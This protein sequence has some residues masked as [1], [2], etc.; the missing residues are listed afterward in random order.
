MHCPGI[1]ILWGACDALFTPRALGPFVDVARVTGGE[2]EE[3][4]ERGGQPHEVLSAF[5]RVVAERPP[6]VVVLEDLH[7]ADEATLDV[8]RLLGRRVDGVR[9]LILATYRDD[10]LDPAH[11]LRVVLGELATGR[12]VERLALT[13]LSL[14]AVAELA[15]PFGVDAE[16]LYRSTGGNPFFV[17]E[18]LAA[19]TRE[20]P[21]TVGDA[22]LARA[23]RLSGGA[24][25]M[26]EALTV[27]FPEAELWVLEAIAG[28]AM[29]HLDNCLGSGMLV[30]AGRGLAFRRE[31]ARLVIEQSLAPH[32][33]AELHGRAL[34]ALSDSPMAG[35]DPARLAH[36]AEAAG[37]AGAVLRF[38][39]EAAERASV[40]GAHRESAAQYAR[41]LRF[42]DALAPERRAA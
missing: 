35:A 23:A 36:H 19:D 15:K 12:G 33:R 42:A 11:P 37:D 30:K 13:P 41:V 4:A 10:E 27:A 22:V 6:T 3:L 20:I 8:V 29:E 17:S 16:A 2:L 18:V 39:S 26:L 32:R 38:A 14:G 40:F 7:W 34:R 5:A 21:S 25:T 1:R 31:R 24:R 28:D 9:A